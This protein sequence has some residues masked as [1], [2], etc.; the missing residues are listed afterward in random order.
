MGTFHLWRNGATKQW[1]WVPLGWGYVLIKQTNRLT[2]TWRLFAE[3]LFIFNDNRHH[4]AQ[5]HAG[6]WGPF[7]CPTG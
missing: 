2:C 1:T 5:H 3:A 6:S 4:L 7:N